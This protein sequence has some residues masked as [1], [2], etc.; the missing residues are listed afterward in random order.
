MKT[1]KILLTITLLALTLF[2]NGQDKYEFL[3]IEFNTSLSILTVSI[4]GDNY[5]KEVVELPKAERLS[6]SNPVLKKV[7]EYQDKDWEVMSFNNH[8]IAL[9]TVMTYNVY[10]AYLRKKKVDKK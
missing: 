5:I 6:N 2:I 10:F 3:T 4:D 1:K 7:K 8:T 9:S